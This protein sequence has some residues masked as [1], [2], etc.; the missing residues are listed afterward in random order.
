MQ[1][2]RLSRIL[3][4]SNLSGLP[5]YAISSDSSLAR[6]TGSGVNP[7]HDPILH[8]FSN[9]PD[10]SH[11]SQKKRITRGDMPHSTVQRPGQDR[12]LSWS[13]GRLPH[14]WHPGSGSLRYL[15]R[16]DTG[17]LPTGQEPGE[18]VTLI[19]VSGAGL[20]GERSPPGSNLSGTIL[21]APD[22]SGR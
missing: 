16:S 17:L 20:P 18:S 21:P 4:S 5:P 2:G 15:L 22:P 13:E 3:I 7:S 9:P 14:R 19:P 12:F 8:L 10:R 11:R 1:N 6:V